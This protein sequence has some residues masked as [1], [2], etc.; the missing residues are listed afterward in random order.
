MEYPVSQ[1]IQNSTKIANK[2]VLIYIK[3]ELCSFL[4]W[5]CLCVNMQF[6]Q[7]V[8]KSVCVNGPYDHLKWFLLFN[9]IWFLPTVQKDLWCG[10]KRILK[11]LSK[12]DFTHSH[13]VI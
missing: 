11:W 3:I 7:I 1:K 12:D 4:R 13:L 8:K 9:V 6:L 10:Q 2:S 5:F